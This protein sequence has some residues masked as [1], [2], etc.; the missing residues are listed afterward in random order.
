MTLANYFTHLYMISEINKNMWYWS[1]PFVI[2]WQEKKSH[3]Y[4]R[5]AYIVHLLLIS[6]T[7]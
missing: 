7:R 5:E 4:Y 6:S 2:L 1:V 3:I